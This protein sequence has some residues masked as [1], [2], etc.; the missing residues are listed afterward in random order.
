MYEFDLFVQMKPMS[1]RYSGSAFV[2]KGTM[3]GI[4]PFLASCPAPLGCWRNLQDAP[5][6]KVCYAPWSRGASWFSVLTS[7]GLPGQ[8]DGTSPE[9]PHPTAQA[10]QIVLTRCFEAPKTVTLCLT[11]STWSNTLAIQNRTP[12]TNGPWAFHLQSSHL[13]TQSSLESKPL[14]PRVL[15]APGDAP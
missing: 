5:Q 10:G 11:A 3:R 2:I 8:R 1:T 4:Q 9:E 12:P 15:V 13:E 14:I 7:Y 6:S